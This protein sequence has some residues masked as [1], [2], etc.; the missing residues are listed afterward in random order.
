MER[1]SRI[2]WCD[3]FNVGNTQINNEHQDLINLYNK[4]GETINL[5]KSTEQIVSVLSELTNYSLKHFKDEEEWMKEIN[6]PDFEVHQ[7]EHKDFIY[8]IAMFNL[9]FSGLDE[10]MI[11][12]IIFFL[13]EWIVNHLMISD[14]KIE[15]FRVNLPKG[16]AYKEL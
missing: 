15:E 6:Y 11:Y 8:R 5:G 14:K 13:K 10:K 2:E 1:F 9:S 16:R 3:Q 7:R 4:M 12:E